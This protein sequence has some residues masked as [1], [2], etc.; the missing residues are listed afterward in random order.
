M[1]VSGGQYQSK[2]IRRA[3]SAN[4]RLKLSISTLYLVMIGSMSDILRALIFDTLNPIRN[5]VLR[6]AF[7]PSQ[8]CYLKGRQGESGTFKLA[9]AHF[10]SDPLY[11]R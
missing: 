3:F 6:I 2:L 5:L 10:Y 4:H 9:R 11:L 1:V 7:V 8:V